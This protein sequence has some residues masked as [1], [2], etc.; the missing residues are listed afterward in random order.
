MD[1]EWIRGILGNVESR[2]VWFGAIGPFGVGLGDELGTR[3]NVI[4]QEAGCIPHALIILPESGSGCVRDEAW[5]RL[6][7]ETIDHGVMEKTTE[8]DLIEICRCGEGRET[9]GFVVWYMSESGI[10]MEEAKTERVCE[11]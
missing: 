5:L 11:L 3:C 10:L 4:E 9:D 1:I 8:K 2:L 6:L 7:C